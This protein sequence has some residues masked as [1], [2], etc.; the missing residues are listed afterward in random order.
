MKTLSRFLIVSVLTMVMAGAV[1]AQE[2]DDTQEEGPN[3]SRFQEAQDEFRENVD[4]EEVQAAIL[5]G[6]SAAQAKLSDVCGAVKAAATS[7]GSAIN[8][9]TAAYILDACDKIKGAL[10]D[11][12]AKV[13]LAKSYEDLDALRAETKTLLQENSDELKAAFEQTAMAIMENAADTLEELK[14]QVD[15]ALDALRVVCPDETATIDSLESQLVT[16]E[17][18]ITE[19]NAALEAEDMDTAKSTLKSGVS[20]AKDIADDVQTLSSSCDLDV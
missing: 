19:L 13:E 5:Q 2:S 1:Y 17:A 9:E 11:Y 12:A 4:Y 20:L 3:G 18:T 8:K 6:V 7:P 10:A 14:D 15:E 16:L